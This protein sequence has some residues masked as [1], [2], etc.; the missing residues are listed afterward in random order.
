MNGVLDWMGVPQTWRPV[1]SAGKDFQCPTNFML[2]INRMLAGNPS[3]AGRQLCRIRSS[4]YFLAS[5]TG[6]RGIRT[7]NHNS[8]F[9]PLAPV[10]TL[11]PVGLPT[12]LS[13]C[14]ALH[15]KHDL[16]PPCEVRRRNI[17]WSSHP[18]SAWHSGWGWAVCSR[19]QCHNLGQSRREEPAHQRS[20]GDAGEVGDEPPQVL[21]SYSVMIAAGWEREDG[22]SALVS[23]AWNE[24]GSTLRQT[25]E[26]GPTM[27]QPLHKAVPPSTAG[28]ERSLLPRAHGQPSSPVPGLGRKN[29][30]SVYHLEHSP[31]GLPFLP[32]CPPS[33]RFMFGERKFSR[34][35]AHSPSTTS[36]LFPP[37]GSLSF[38]STLSSLLSQPCILKLSLCYHPNWD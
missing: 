26:D 4:R 33:L 31:E 15:S 7:I 25:G 13:S 12:P 22:A 9:L 36:H 20:P 29:P 5:R 18:L 8:L 14:K 6:P 10:L 27:S 17:L 1:V 30:S 35:S 24:H 38:S 34:T 28:P 21:L 16:S 37:P 19:A 2:Q 23:A 32:T 11:H 3:L